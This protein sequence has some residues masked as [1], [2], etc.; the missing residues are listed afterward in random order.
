MAIFTTPCRSLIFALGG[1]GNTTGMLMFFLAL[2]A[3]GSVSVTAALKNT[4]PLFT[5]LKAGFF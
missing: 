5:L 1:F 3:G 4:S 2:S